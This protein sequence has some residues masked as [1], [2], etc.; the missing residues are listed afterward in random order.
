MWWTFGF[1]WT[2]F[3]KSYYT[4]VT[5][6]IRTTR[7]HVSKINWWQLVYTN[8]Y[9]QQNK[10]WCLFVFCKIEQ[11]KRKSLPKYSGSYPLKHLNNLASFLGWGRWFAV[12][13]TNEREPLHCTEWN[14][15]GTR[16]NRCWG[17]ILILCTN[18]YLFF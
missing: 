2:L 6:F 13:S 1:L 12:T 15:T 14:K 11:K 8:I 7:L 18:L 5:H 3:S 4:L 16:E 17:I 9:L 10:L